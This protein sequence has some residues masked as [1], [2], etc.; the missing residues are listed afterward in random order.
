MLEF[1]I[2]SRFHFC[3]ITKHYQ[4]QQETF[5]LP[6]NSNY[7]VTAEY[8]ISNTSSSGTSVKIDNSMF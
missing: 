1:C 4:K 8:K 3:L 5:Y 7:C 6:L 2:L